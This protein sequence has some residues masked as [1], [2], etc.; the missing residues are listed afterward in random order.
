MMDGIEAHDPKQCWALAIDL[1]SSCVRVTVVNTHGTAL[2]NVE[3]YR[4]VSMKDHNGNGDNTFSASEY[5]N[6]AIQAIDDAL[7]S[8]RKKND[9][10]VSLASCCPFS[11]CCCCVMVRLRSFEMRVS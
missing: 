11:A 2:K 6:T 1:G 4:S 5:V 9:N 7:E 10:Q 8:L 3:G